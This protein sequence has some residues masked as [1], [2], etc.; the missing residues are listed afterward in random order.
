MIYRSAN[1]C[2][3]LTF[4]TIR[5]RFTTFSPSKL[6]SVL[7]YVERL[8]LLSHIKSMFFKTFLLTCTYRWVWINTVWGRYYWWESCRHCRFVY[9]ALNVQTVRIT[10][11][12]QDP[13][14]WL[15]VIYTVSNV[16]APLL[17]AVSIIKFSFNW[18]LIIEG[19]NHWD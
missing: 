15:P 14:L 10:R 4:P 19:I 11:S 8:T 17:S 1:I 18:L 3:T 13:V 7:V 2:I 16:S 5:P 9:S 6:V 12:T